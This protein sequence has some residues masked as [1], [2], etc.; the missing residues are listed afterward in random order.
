MALDR[1]GQRLQGILEHW[2]VAAV[3]RVKGGHKHRQWDA[4]WKY[5]IRITLTLSSPLTPFHFVAWRAHQA[6]PFVTQPIACK[7]KIQPVACGSKIQTKGCMDYPIRIPQQ[8]SS[9]LIAFRKHAGLSQAEVAAQL[10]VTQQAVS[11]LERNA[12]SM[13]VARLMSL[14][15]LLGVV[16]VLREREGQASDTPEP[17][18]SIPPW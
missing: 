16:L 11:D 8:L 18:T 10:G 17:S 14:L 13:S 2:H 12:E 7:I 5:S 9:I 4:V 1:C 6:P 15:S 3:R